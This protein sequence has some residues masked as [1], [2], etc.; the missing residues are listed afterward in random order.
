MTFDNL[1]KIPMARERVYMCVCG[2]E[3]AK[4]IISTQGNRKK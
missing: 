3:R 4:E 1:F 2:L